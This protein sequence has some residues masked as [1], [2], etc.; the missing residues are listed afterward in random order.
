MTPDKPTFV[1]F[2][3]GATRAHHVPKAWIDKWKAS[4]T[5]AGTKLREETL[6][7]QIA[8]GVCRPERSWRRCRGDQDWDKLS[9]RRETFTTPGRGLCLRSPSTPTTRSAAC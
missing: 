3:P 2:A 6:A 5:W 4:S 8:L 9:G 7:R 1:Y